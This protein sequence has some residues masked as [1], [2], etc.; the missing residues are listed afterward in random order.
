MNAYK[1]N[2]EVILTPSYIAVKLT[3]FNTNTS[4]VI[5]QSTLAAN[6]SCKLSEQVGLPPL[7]LLTEKEEA[8]SALLAK[9]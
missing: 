1:T 6:R 3:T 4:V 9:N 5:G 7:A 8:I 2:I